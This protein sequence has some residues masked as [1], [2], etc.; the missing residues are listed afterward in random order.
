[1]LSVGD[2]ILLHLLTETSV[3]V[4]LP[5]D[6]YCQVMGTPIIYS[7]PPTSLFDTRVSD[8]IANV[9][10]PA[11]SQSR[12][13]KAIHVDEGKSLRPEKRLKVTT[14]WSFSIQAGKVPTTLK[15]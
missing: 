13:R 3:Y 11:R 1:M 4:A 15:A 9:T 14:S 2:A 10:K 5:N 7:A 8:K 12:K 6:C